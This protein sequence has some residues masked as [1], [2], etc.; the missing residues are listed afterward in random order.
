M[1]ESAPVFY[2]LTPERWQDFET[3]FGKN[4]ACAGCWCMWWRV[5]QSTFNQN[6]YEGNRLAM[7]GIVEAEKV[8]GI[9]AYL[10]GDPVGW[11]S[12]APREDFSRLDRSRVLQRVDERPVWSVVCFFVKRPYRRAGLTAGLL[13]AAVGYA[14]QQGAQVVEGYPIDKPGKFSTLE[15][16]TGTASTFRRAGFVEVARRSPTRPVMRLDLA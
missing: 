1:A 15:D 10:D 5:P 2:P 6:H 14:R 11:C 7:Q 12:I 13:N 8:P 3:L 16:Y 4:G 9:M